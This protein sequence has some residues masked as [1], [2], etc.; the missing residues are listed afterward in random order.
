MSDINS[1]IDSI[2]SLS[3]AN[4]LG[5]YI[6]FIQFP[7]YR[8]LEIN[9]RINFTFPFTVFVGQNGSGK[10]STLHALYGAPQGH[11]PYEFW[12]DTVVDPI[13]YYSD[14]HKRH[15][16]FYS[17]FDKNGD[18]LEVVKARIRRKGNPNYWETSRPLRWA[19]MKSLPE[20]VDRE[21]NPP[22]E[23]NVVY[24]DFRSEL[25]A[26]DKYF[27][28]REPTGLKA[29]NKQEYLRKKSKHLKKVFSRSNH[30]VYGPYNVKQNEPLENLTK[31]ELDIVSFILGRK[32]VEGKIVEH[33]IFTDWGYSVKFKT[34]RASYSE[35]FAGSGEVAI[36]RLVREIY[37][38][39]D[40][41]L[42]LLDEP[43][44]SLHPGAQHRL[45]LF[46]LEQIKSKKHQI[47]LSTHSPTFVEELPIDAI[48]VFYQNP[49][50]GRFKV[51]EERTYKEAF[52]HIELTNPDKTEIIVEDL[53]SKKIIESVINS[54]GEE[55]VSI[56]HVKFFPGGSS[57][58][59]NDFIKVF[60][61]EEQ[62]NRH[63]IFDGDQKPNELHFDPLELSD[64]EKTV[65]NLKKLV[66]K[67]VG[68]KISFTPDGYKGKSDRTGKI[69]LIMK[70]L[71]YYKDYVHYLPGDQPEQIIWNREY[72]ENLLGDR[73][74]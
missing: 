21:R 68:M 9:T 52:Y 25:S 24:L 1:L 11:T 50:T 26:F 43:E 44:V 2:K 66:K 35:A 15:S 28:F 7:F 40:Y 29:K 18:E 34:E 8:N 64:K 47:V 62:K 69:D 54:I 12:F 22:L 14:E 48:K 33:K 65:A 51:D 56:T 32:Y 37:Q 58:I 3:A 55:V 6:N 67:Q 57:A 71:T 42:I 63:I 27:Y 59:K 20:D 45:K 19:G 53:L 13:R 60:S 5:R 72:A 31:Q 74:D 23:K 73:N 10:S 38:A 46:L 36:V 61:Q 30:I 16:F 41:S 39:P 17:Y 4:M 49:A 70:Y